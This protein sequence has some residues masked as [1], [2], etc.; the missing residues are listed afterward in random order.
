MAI[1]TSVYGTPESW[2]DSEY[3]ASGTMVAKVANFGTTANPASTLGDGH[4]A[5][6]TPRNQ[7]IDRSISTAALGTESLYS[8][9]N[10]IY[11][12]DIYTD[13]EYLTEYYWSECDPQPNRRN[14]DDIYAPAIDIPSPWNCWKSYSADPDNFYYNYSSLT[15][16]IT[17]LDP[18]K[19]L[20]VLQV[21]P[22]K[23]DGTVYNSWV[24]FGTYDRN[25]NNI[26]TNY[27]YIIAARLDPRIDNTSTTTPNRVSFTDPEAYFGISINREFTACPV[28]DIKIYY[29]IF[30]SGGDPNRIP[31][32]GSI[33]N[34]KVLIDSDYV[35]LLLCD[36]QDIVIDSQYG[37]AYALHEYSS[38][39][40]EYLKRQAACLGVYFRV[41][42]QGEAAGGIATLALDSAGVCLGVLDEYGVGHGDYTQG[43]ANR[44]NPIWNWSSYNQSPYD[45]TREIPSDYDTSNHFNS[46]TLAS[47]NKV[48]VGSYNEVEDLVHELYEGLSAKPIDVY[49]TDYSVD[50]YLSTNAIDG[51]LS[52]RRFPLIRVPCTDTVYP[53]TIGSYQSNTVNV[54]K[55][56]NAAGSQFIDFKFNRNKRLDEKFGGSFL[57]R[58]PYTTAELYIPFCGTVPISIADYIGHDITVKLAIDYKTG[59]CTAYVLKDNTP[60]QSANGQIGVD[61]PVS[62]IQSATLDGQLMNANLALKQSQTNIIAG[63]V[64]AFTSAVGSVASVAGG[65]KYGLTSA[66]SSAGGIVSQIASVSNA[67]DRKDVLA[68]ELHHQQPPVKSIS[69]GSP[70]TAAMG[71][72]CCRLT[73]YRPIIS[74]DYDSDVYAKTV[75]FACLINGKVRDFSGLTLGIIS[76]DGVNATAEEKQLIATAFKQGVFL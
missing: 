13:D 9:I 72:H 18:K 7:L 40:G 63:G 55:F 39:F 50:T 71:E 33:N 67:I 4:T 21:L 15:K 11:G 10:Y 73:I 52:V 60:L 31:I 53:L 34:G 61:I 59:S 49:T 47:C 6:K 46:I 1:N 64:G 19:I 17:E 51:I 58:E 25:A 38:D 48:W 16:P 41:S 14:I 76:L 24:F 12:S 65:G 28:D 62:G 69:A 54:R 29:T 68:Y 57:D 43:A 74:D 30:R 2:P 5:G 35:S 26:Q 23:E 20:Y 75:G 3:L 32:Y 8:H 66:A 37:Q 44:N 22:C 36:P 56:V 27:P 45:Y 70:T 42:D